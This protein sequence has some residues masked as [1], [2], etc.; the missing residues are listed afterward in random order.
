MWTT[1]ELGFDP[2]LRQGIFLYPNALRP[3][4]GPT[5]LVIQWVL[6]VLSTERK[7]AEV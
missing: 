2:Q 1:N 3:A 5:Q 4:L 6:W 7:A